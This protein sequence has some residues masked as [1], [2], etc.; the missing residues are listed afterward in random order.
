MPCYAAIMLCGSYLSVY[1]IDFDA[2]SVR[3]IWGNPK[4]MT[5]DTLDKLSGFEGLLIP[6]DKESYDVQQAY[7]VKARN[8][9]SIRND[10]RA[11]LE[12]ANPNF[13]VNNMKLSDF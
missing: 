2:R 3:F 12:A 4:N 11:A 13:S 5:T 8:N 10:T 6:N 7:F 9:N 1:E